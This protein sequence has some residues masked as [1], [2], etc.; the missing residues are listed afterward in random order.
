MPDF[1]VKS[2]VYHRSKDAKHSTTLTG[3]RRNTFTSKESKTMTTPSVS[4]QQTSAA[5]ETLPAD[6]IWYHRE[7]C[8]LCQGTN[9]ELA[10]P[11]KPI[12]MAEK[13]FV[14]KPAIPQPLFPVNLYL[15]H[16][17]GHM[18]ILDVIR[19]ELLWSSYTYYSGQTQGIIDH[20][21][22][23]SRHIAK[24][25]PQSARRFVVDIGSNDGT[26]L[27][28]FQQMDYEVLGVDPAKE[29]AEQATRIGIHTLPE[30]M[31]PAL[32]REIVHLHG[33]AGIVTA[34]N[35]FA[36]AD[37]MVSLAES[38]RILLAEDGLFVFEVSY[39]LDIVDKM[40][41]GTIF[42]EHLCHHSLQPM[43]RFLAKFD[44]EIVAV[45]RIPI[46]GG[47][48]IGYAQPLNGPRNIMP[49]V[50][51]LLQLETDSLLDS[52]ARYTAF[53]EQLQKMQNAVTAIVQACVGNGE[54]IA[55]YGAARSGPMLITQ[56]GL[57]KVIDVVFDDHPDKTGLLTPGDYIPVVPTSELDE[58]QPDLTFILAWIHAKKIIRKHRSYLEKGGRF[59][60]LTPQIKVISITEYFNYQ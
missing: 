38:I 40:L 29:I 12:P 25:F 34:F 21:K 20:F 32:A 31:T 36:H 22:Q 14:R 54:K 5:H 59:V 7:D 41:I 47:S 18:Q 23:T 51:T 33:R 44:L 55:G 58:I 50:A 28:F 53:V 9:V 30:L 4:L 11:F 8:R 48:L 3:E 35:V 2:K 17:C 60:I 49:S 19:P 39:L 52:R 27:S 13:Y 56:F 1:L 10:I 24:D 26:L 15:C 46:Q 37:D 42:H 57:N 45:E 43:Q 16:D 6:A